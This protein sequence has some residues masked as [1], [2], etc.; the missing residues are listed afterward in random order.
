MFLLLLFKTLPASFEEAPST[1]L[2]VNHSYNTY[3]YLIFTKRPYHTR[4]GSC[5]ACIFLAAM[6]QVSL[7]IASVLLELEIP[8]RKCVLDL[9]S[10]VSIL[11]SK[12]T[13]SR[14]LPSEAFAKGRPRKNMSSRWGLRAMNEKPGMRQ[15]CKS[16]LTELHAVL[17]T[18]TTSWFPFEV[19][20]KASNTAKTRGARIVNYP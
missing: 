6:F 1:V 14:N 10:W 3:H 15:L 2:W 4:S 20:I 13:Q 19:H 11:L 7:V 16:L 12:C 9:N 8:Q 5:L 17:M 18:F